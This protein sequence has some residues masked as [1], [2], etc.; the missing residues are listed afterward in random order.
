MGTVTATPLQV[1]VALL[2]SQSSLG[3]ERT[4]TSLSVRGLACQFTPGS[5]RGN[6]LRGCEGTGTSVSGSNLFILNSV[7]PSYSWEGLAGLS[8]TQGTG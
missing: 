7:P 1:G 6:S 5:L 3:R 2:T 8:L 4:S